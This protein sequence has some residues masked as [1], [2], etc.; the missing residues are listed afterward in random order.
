ME[1]QGAPPLFVGVP[2]DNPPPTKTDAG[3]DPM[4]QQRVDSQ[5]SDRQPEGD[6]WNCDRV[7]S[8][9]SCLILP[10]PQA[11]R[12]KPHGPERGGLTRARRAGDCSVTAL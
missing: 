8:G 11:Q 10:V 4:L 2:G 6:L 7:T 5:A 9:I 1:V 12:R 3:N